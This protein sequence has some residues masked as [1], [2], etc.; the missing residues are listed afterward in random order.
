MSSKEE[1]ST[2][3]VQ[4]STMEGG[5][6]RSPSSETSDQTSGILALMQK[7]SIFLISFTEN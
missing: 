6:Q 7:V 1:A 2:E 3:L 5:V 4:I